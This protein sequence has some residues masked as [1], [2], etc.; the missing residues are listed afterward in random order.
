MRD[1]KGQ[2]YSKSKGNVVDPVDLMDK[3]GADALRFTLASL[4]VQGR[5][6]KLAESRIAGYRNFATKIWNAARFCQLNDAAYTF[7][8]SIRRPTPTGSTAGSSA[9]WRSSN[10]GSGPPSKATAS[11]RR[12]TNSTSLSGTAIATGISNSPS[13]CLQSDDPAVLAETRATALWTLHKALTMLHPFMP[14]VTEELWEQTGSGSRQ[15]S[16]SLLIAA[17]WPA[18]DRGLVDDPAPTA[19]SAGWSKSSRASGRFAAR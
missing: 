14:F 3:Y 11:T 8:I 9:S 18:I 7:R 19:N 13:R 15:G 12:P 5:D 17:N 16:G 4:A 10:R 2:K 6:I 1:A